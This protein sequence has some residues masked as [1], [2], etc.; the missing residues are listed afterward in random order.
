MPNKHLSRIALDGP[1]AL[2]WYRDQNDARSQSAP[3][4]AVNAHVAAEVNVET[5]QEDGLDDELVWL[6]DEDVAMTLAE[7]SVFGGLFQDAPGENPNETAGETSLVRTRKRSYERCSSHARDIKRLDWASLGLREPSDEDP[8]FVIVSERTAR[9]RV[10]NIR[11]RVCGAQLPIGSLHLLGG[12]ALVPSPELTFLLLA[13]YLSVVELIAVGME[14]CGYYRLAGAKSASVLASNRTL[15][16]QAPLTSVASLMR[17][18]DKCEGFPGAAHAR[19]ACRYMRDGSASPMETA[20]YM[21]LCLPRMLGGYGLPAPILNG[22]RAVNTKAMTFTL[23][24]YLIPDL[25][26]S[27]ARLDVEYDSEAFH[28]SE[29]GLRKGARRT[30]AMRAMNVEVVSLTSEVVRDVVAFETVASLIARRLN[31]RMAPARKNFGERRDE[32]RAAVL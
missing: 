17:F 13:R 20:L 12:M 25:Y 15:Y 29:D 28:A 9:R 30:L 1:S 19:R 16:G 10:S 8:L 2:I 18:L 4:Y 26:W 14:M 21:L 31:K 23:A 11:V 27:A 3:W 22:K 7:T 5:T 6:S 24:N 32:L